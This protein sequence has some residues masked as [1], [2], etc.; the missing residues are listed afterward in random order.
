MAKSY[1]SEITHFLQKLKEERPQLD[2][3]QQQ[4][5]ARLWDK[6]IDPELTQE[7]DASTVSQKPYVYFSAD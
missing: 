7:F 1:E 5:R 6:T 2:A 3:E 4:G